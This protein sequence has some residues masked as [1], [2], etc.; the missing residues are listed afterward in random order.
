MSGPPPKDPKLRRRKSTPTPGFKR[1]PR[2]GR[3]GD[4]PPWPLTDP[5]PEE[6]LQ[7]NRLWRLPQA[8]EWERMQCEDVVALYVRAF[9][10]AS[11][12]VNTK[13]LSEVRQLDSKIGLSPRA[14]RDLRWEVDDPQEEETTTPRA[15]SNGDRTY[16]PRKPQSEGTT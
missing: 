5:A 13:L 15:R 8:L 7:W 2:E 12:G 6:T 14:M 10:V 16:V 1:L 9:V 11:K 3:T 4:P